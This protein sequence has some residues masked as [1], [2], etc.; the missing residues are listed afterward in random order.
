MTSSLRIAVAMV[1]LLG[2]TAL[3]LI[4]LS[5]NKPPAPVAARSE[6]APLLTNYLVAARPL[7]A[8]T[9]AREEDFRA[10]GAPAGALPAGAVLDTADA[11]ADLR[12]SLVL[13]FLDT[14]GP[15]TVA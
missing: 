1:M 7:A 8:G 11:R 12:G 9:L 4:T 6:P 15:I 3:V 2:A 10:Q 14:G 5:N 13:N